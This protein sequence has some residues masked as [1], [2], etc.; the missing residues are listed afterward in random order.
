[1]RPDVDVVH[2]E[3]VG[4]V[5]ERFEHHAVADTRIGHDHGVRADVAVAPDG[6]GAVDDGIGADRRPGTDTDGTPADDGCVDRPGDLGFDPPEHP[7]V[8][9]QEIP[10]VDGVL[11]VVCRD[12]PYRPA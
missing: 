2:D 10:G 5:G 11:P 7:A 1:M 9:F 6:D 3:R 12:R 4:D 8:Q